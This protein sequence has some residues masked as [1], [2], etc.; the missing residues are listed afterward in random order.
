MTELE[1]AYVQEPT[2]RGDAGFIAF[3]TGFTYNPAAY[4]PAVGRR[5]RVI[6]AADDGQEQECGGA[7]Q[8]VTP[9]VRVALDGDGFH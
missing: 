9:V 4:E 8:T 2:S 3:S 5:C 6:R 1:A 7:V